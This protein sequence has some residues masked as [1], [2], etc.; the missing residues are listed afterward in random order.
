MYVRPQALHRSSSYFFLLVLVVARIATVEM[1]R[2]AGADAPH[3]QD[4]C[5][6]AC[7]TPRAGCYRCCWWWGHKPTTVVARGGLFLI[8]HHLAWICP[9][10]PPLA[11]PA[12]RRLLT[13]SLNSFLQIDGGASHVIFS[14]SSLTLWNSTDDR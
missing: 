11:P 7:R 5:S 4:T 1:R 3:Q 2:P 14:H 13:A 12:L 8:R 10:P 6:L 9:P